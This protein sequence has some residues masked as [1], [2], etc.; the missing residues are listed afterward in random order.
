MKPNTRCTRC[1]RSFRGVGVFTGP[2][3]NQCPVCLAFLEHEK[4]ELWSLLF[5]CGVIIACGLAGFIVCVLLSSCGG[6]PFTSEQAGRLEQGGAGGA[7]TSGGS[8]GVAI[9]SA[10]GRQNVPNSSGSSGMGDAGAGGVAIACELAGAATA[11]A[12]WTSGDGGPPSSALDGSS[13]TRWASGVPQAPGQWFQVA[14]PAP[15]ELERLVL[16]S[17]PTDAPAA[18]TLE[19][20]GV[21]VPVTLSSSPGSLELEFAPRRASVIRL[22]LEQPSTSWWS[23]DELDAECA[24]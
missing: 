10:A 12:S 5:D 9:A 15:L 2:L 21:V 4:A 18:V 16:A 17:R 19:L 23:I 7:E 1:N 24:P 20:D 22:E 14:L 8:G 6:A 13:S 3:G 11:F